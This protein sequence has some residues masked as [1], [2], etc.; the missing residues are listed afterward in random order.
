MVDSTS[1][2]NVDFL[3]PFACR[4][5]RKHW[6]RCLFSQLA[7][8]GTIACSLHPSIYCARESASSVPCSHQEA[9]ILCEVNSHGR[10][11]L[12]HRRDV[13]P[14]PVHAVLSW[15]IFPYHQVPYSEITDRP[16]TSI[17]SPCPRHPSGASQPR[18]R[19]RLGRAR[20]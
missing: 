14:R 7:Y 12:G 8:K 10:R 9:E 13:P 1:F 3:I 18:L 5:P 4:L 16:T 2:S 20:P 6:A 15:P 17:H 11:G 19:P